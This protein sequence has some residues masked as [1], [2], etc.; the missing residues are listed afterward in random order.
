[1]RVGPPPRFIDEENK[2]L[3]KWAKANAGYFASLWPRAQSYLRRDFGASAT[4]LTVF[5]E[6]CG[7][8]VQK[9]VTSPS[10]TSL[11]V[12]RKR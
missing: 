3:A 11:T 6:W 7:P 4:S 10:L 5:G 9:G 2:G 8:G 12:V 1:V